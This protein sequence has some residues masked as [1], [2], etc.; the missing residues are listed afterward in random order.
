MRTCLLRCCAVLL[1][2]SCV[3]A[4]KQPAIRLRA[5]LIDFAKASCLYWYFSKK[6]YDLKDI[7]GISSGMVELGSNSAE[8]Y[9]R[10]SLLVKQYRPPLKTKQDIDIDLLKCF[11]MEHDAAFLR[12]LTGAQ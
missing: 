2:S 7:R 6:G 4:G 1:L 5:E 8:E 11:T 10:V 3:P 9:E 12:A